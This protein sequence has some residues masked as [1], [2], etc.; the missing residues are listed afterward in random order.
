[1]RGRRGVKKAVSETGK[2]TSYVGRNGK[3][4]FLMDMAILAQRLWK[5]TKS[6]A[7]NPESARRPQ[8]T[9][10]SPGADPRKTPDFVVE[11]SVMGRE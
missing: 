6:G 4:V 8:N 1:M 10:T 2:I 9:Y 3:P 11:L 7:P 5:C